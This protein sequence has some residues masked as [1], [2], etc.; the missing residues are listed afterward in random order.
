MSEKRE[1]EKKSKE[2]EPAPEQK[3][4]E[5]VLAE[6]ERQIAEYE[7]KIENIQLENF[8]DSRLQESRAKNKRAVKALIDM[9]RVK[10]EDGKIL[11]VDEQ[12]Q[13]IRVTDGYLFEMPT[14]GGTNPS[15][16]KGTVDMDALSDDEYF[17]MKFGR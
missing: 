9:Q 13:S 14:T 15:G 1:T 11:G 5:Q 3:S 2:S 17:R 6:K 10:I 12:I 4:M 16:T 8:L 7:K